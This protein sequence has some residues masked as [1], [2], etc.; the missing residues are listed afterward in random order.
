MKKKVMS[1]LGMV[2]AVAVMAGCGK[3]NAAPAGA[4]NA[5]GAATESKEETYKSADG[6]SVRYEAG[7][8]AVNE[9]DAHTTSFVY[10]KDS[11]GT[12]MVTITYV[13]GKQPEE[14]MSEL[15]EKW[16]N[17][18]RTEGFFPGT[19]DK[20]GYWRTLLPEEN[21]SGLSET[22]IAGEYNGGALLF[23]IVSHK[24]EDDEQNMMVS[25]E[26]A[27]IIDSIV[28]DSF[29]EQ[30]MYDYIPGTYERTEEEAVHSVI[31]NGDHTGKLSFQD[32]ID[33]LWGAYELIAADGSF[34]YEYTIEGTT[35]ML[36]YDGEWLEFEKK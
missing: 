3:G 18:E 33:I 12:N 19:N 28:Y 26:L 4:G 36:N 7:D 8:F 17:Q 6:W 29:G 20:W 27:G 2:M 35:L 15:T 23:D 11:A 5:A 30:S 22:V 24:G 16:E 25:D 31:L 13:D 21:D 14:A 9:P 10:Q 34:H 1:V 32:D